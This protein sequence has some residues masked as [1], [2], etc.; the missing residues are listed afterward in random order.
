VLQVGVGDPCLMQPRCHP[1]PNL[2]KAAEHRRFVELLANEIVEREALDPLHL[3]DGIPVAADADSLIQVGEIN[4]K[5][6]FELLQGAADFLVAVVQARDFTRETLDC[7]AGTVA[8]V[9]LIDVRKIAGTRHGQADF[10]GRRFAPAQFGVG[11]AGGGALDR[12]VIFLR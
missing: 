12:L 2:Q 5:R 8:T 7:P 6:Q 1:R 10:I 3:E 11:E 9:H 4:R